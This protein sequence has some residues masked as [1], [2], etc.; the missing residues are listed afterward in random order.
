MITATDLTI[1]HYHR[2]EVRAAILRYCQDVE[3][4]RALNG[5]DGWHK[6]RVKAGKVRLATPKDYESLVEKHRTLYATLVELIKI[7]NR[8]LGSDGYSDVDVGPITDSPDG[9]QRLRNAPNVD[10]PGLDGIDC[11][12]GGADE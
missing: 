5:D 12:G 8:F 4:W 1:E 9:E 11:C 10:D 2:P 7:E 6:R 3:A